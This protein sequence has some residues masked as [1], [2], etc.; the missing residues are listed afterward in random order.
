MAEI[1]TADRVRELLACP[2]PVRERGV[3]R[4]WGKDGY[5][6]IRRAG[7]RGNAFFRH[8]DAHGYIRVGDA[9]TFDVVMRK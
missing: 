6:F 7:D 8:C 2:V 5:G 4:H 1:L 3:V 9:V